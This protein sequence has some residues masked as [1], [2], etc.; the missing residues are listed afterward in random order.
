MQSNW[1]IYVLIIYEL[2]LVEIK[3]PPHLKRTLAPQVSEYGNLLPMMKTHHIQENPSFKNP[4]S[5]NLT[6]RKNF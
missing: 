6:A 2:W 1:Y 3:I 4:M 5:S